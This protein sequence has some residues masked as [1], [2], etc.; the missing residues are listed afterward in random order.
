MLQE[1]VETTAATND[2]YVISNNHNFI[3]GMKVQ[4]KSNGHTAITG[5]VEDQIYYV[6]DATDT[7]FKLAETKDDRNTIKNISGG[8]LKNRFINV[9]ELLHFEHGVSSQQI[10]SLLSYQDLF[11]YKNYLEIVSAPYDIIQMILLIHSQL[12]QNSIMMDLVYGNK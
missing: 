12:K 11:P 9:D 3:N 8:T 10:T 2:N 1:Y 5:L 7:S 4:Y 6:I